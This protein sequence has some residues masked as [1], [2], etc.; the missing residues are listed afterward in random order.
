ML[1]KAGFLIGLLM[2]SACASTPKDCLSVE[3]EPVS[4]CRAQAACAPS[5]TQR[6]GIAM[7]GAKS[8]QSAAMVAYRSESCQTNHIEAQKSN[9]ALRLLEKSTQQA[10]D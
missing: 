9:A 1:K 10:S 4:L 3:Q 6:L 7:S 2:L 5:F 8:S